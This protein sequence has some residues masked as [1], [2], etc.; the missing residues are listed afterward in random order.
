MVRDDFYRKTRDDRVELH[1]VQEQEEEEEQ[2]IRKSESCG[3]WRRLDVS[4][5]SPAM[6]KAP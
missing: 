2:D 1:F 3:L 4:V 6:R 5:G